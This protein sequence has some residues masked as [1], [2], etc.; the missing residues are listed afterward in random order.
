MI[1]ISCVA[2]MSP[3]VKFATRTKSVATG[4]RFELGSLSRS[5]LM[6]RTLLVL[7]FFFVAAV[8]HAAF[9]TVRKA[10]GLQLSL[11]ARTVGTLFMVFFISLC[12]S[13]LAPFRCDSHPNGLS[14][15]QAYHGVF[16]NGRDEHLQMALIGGFA[17]LLPIAFLVL[18]S[19][20]ILRELPKRLES[21]D[22]Q[23]VRACSFLFVR[24]R[25]G[26]EVFSVI[27][28]V[29]NSLVVLC[30]LLPSTSG[31]VLCLNL[32]LYVSLVV[33]AFSK[34]WRAMA[35]NYLDIVL[36]T[37]MLVILDM[38]SLFVGEVDAEITVVICMLFSSLMVAA[39]LGAILY[40]IVKH[41][42]QK[43]RKPFRFF[44]CH[45]KVAAGSYARL[46]KME[47]QK[48]GSRFTTFV[49]CDDLN[50]LTRLFSY[51]GQDTE[52]FVILGSQ[53]T[54]GSAHVTR[55]HFA[56]KP[57]LPWQAFLMFKPVRTGLEGHGLAWPFLGR[58]ARQRV[59]EGARFGSPILPWFSISS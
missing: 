54:R 37:G 48:R 11:L 13:L 12:S 40:G 41:F 7:V 57:Q 32:L 46:L 24:F 58:L 49:D 21:A 52:T 53:D 19:W 39:I 5:V 51:V 35:C 27:F 30:P 22:V 20:I 56:S 55:A 31:K 44:L 47:L 45:Q 38:G 26:A 15:V 14:T 36:V 34:P 10:K 1:S 4:V 9:L 18:C 29:R 3:V 43:Y 23:F 50:D 42:M 8:V 33:T 17:C 25:P 16:C 6:S 28:L 59:L 2:P